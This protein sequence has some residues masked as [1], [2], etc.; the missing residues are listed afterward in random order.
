M[1]LLFAAAWVGAG[2]FS[3]D[4]RLV[5]RL[6]CAVGVV[7]AGWLVVRE[8]YRHRGTPAVAGSGPGITPEVKV[9]AGT[10]AWMASFLV[11]V[12]LG[13]YVAAL[14]VFLPAFLLWVARA[15]PRTVVVYTL[16]AAVLVAGLPALLPIDLPVGLLLAY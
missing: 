8:V 3:P 9:A 11:L 2:S 4:A 12:V 5:P 14:L 1:L 10:F 16:V 7:V 6:I 15:R 13:G